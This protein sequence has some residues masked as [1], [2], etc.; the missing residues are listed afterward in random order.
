MQEAEVPFDEIATPPVEATAA[1]QE[2]V[3]VTKEESLL[4]YDYDDYDD[5]GIP[6]LRMDSL[7]TSGSSLD[8]D[9]GANKTTSLLMLQEQQDEDE[10]DFEPDSPTAS[11]VTSTS[12]S[13][14]DDDDD[15]D[16]ENSVAS[17]TFAVNGGDNGNNGKQVLLPDFDDRG[18]DR[19]SVAFAL[20]DTMCAPV[21]MVCSPKQLDEE[22]NDS[23]G[24]DDIRKEDDDTYTFFPRKEQKEPK[25]QLGYAA[26]ASEEAPK[27]VLSEAYDSWNTFVQKMGSQLTMQEFLERPAPSFQSAGSE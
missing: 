20:V 11:I 24:D 17:S 16:D 25:F 4:N 10:E 7:A 19:E 8:Q 22:Y 14:D 5:E 18:Y 2:E 23:D 12:S 27:T 26:C 13:V 6:D 9:M 1:V 15:D 3:E 21:D